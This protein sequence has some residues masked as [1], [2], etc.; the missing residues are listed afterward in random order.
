M[1]KFIAILLTI[2]LLKIG[3]L[4][5]EISPYLIGNNY[6]YPTSGS[7]QTLMQ[8]GNAID[9]ADFQTIRIGG[10]GANGYTNAQFIQY[11][12]EIQ[13]IG[14]EPIVQV[15]AS[16]TDAQV[17]D[18]IS[19]INIENELGVKFWAIGNEPD[20]D[21]GG[22]LSASQV[23][24]YIRQIAPILKSIDPS[25]KIIGPA[26]AGYSSSSFDQLLGGS[27]D[28]SGKDDNGNYYIDVFSFHTY[29]QIEITGIESNVDNLLVKL[30][31]VNADRPEAPISWMMGEFNMHWD[32]EEVTDPDG[33]VWSFHAGHVFADFYN[34]GMRKGASIL[35]PWSIFEGDGNRSGGDLGLFDVGEPPL[36]RSSYYH[37][38]MLGQNM[39]K[40]LTTDA[41]TQ[42]DVR[43]ISMKDSTGVS[44][45]IMNR[46]KEKSYT[47]SLKLNNEYGTNAPLQIKVDA[48]I[49][50][51]ITGVIP[52]FA[53]QMLAFDA[54]GN[55][56]KQYTYTSR[57]ADLQQGPKIEMM[58][59]A[60]N[61][62]PTIN[63]IEK[64]NIPADSGSYTVQ[65]SGIS[66]GNNCSQ[67]LT[68]EAYSLNPAIANASN[69][70][71]TSC[72]STGT[73]T[74]TPKKAGRTTI[75]VKLTDGGE[76]GCNNGSVKYMGI[77]VN[78]YAIHNIPALVECEDYFENKGLI[79]ENSTLGTLSFGYS[80]VGDYL[81]YKVNA[82]YTGTHYLTVGLASN[83]TTAA[84]INILEDNTKLAT[85][86]VE[87]TGGWQ[88]WATQMVSF[89]L[90]E[91]IHTLKLEF[92]KAGANLDFL[93][94]TTDPGTNN[95]PYTAITSPKQGEKLKSAASIVLTASGLDMDDA[96]EKVDFFV[97][98]NLVGTALNEPYQVEWISVFPGDH[99]L[100]TQIS[101]AVGATTE[102]KQ[103]SS[104][105]LETSEA[106]EIPGV[107]EA[108]SY[109]AMEGIQTEECTEGGLN[110]GYINAGDWLDY[111][112]SVPVPGKYT[113]KGR[114]SGWAN[115]SSFDLKDAAGTSL[116]TIEIPNSD[117]YQEWVDTEV[118][119]EFELSSGQQIIRI[120]ANTDKMNLNNF[121][122]EKVSATEL[123]SLTLSPSSAK[124]AIGNSIKIIATAVDANN[125][126]LYVNP[127]FSV[128]NNGLIN[129]YGVFLAHIDGTF[130]VTA[131][132]ADLE[133]S[134]SID[135]VATQENYTVSFIISD[136]ENS[137]LRNAEIKLQGYSQKTNADGKAMFTNIAPAEDMVFTI[138]KANYYDT[139]NLVTITNNDIE[140]EITMNK[141]ATSIDVSMENNIQLFPN[142]ATGNVVNIT[143]AKGFNL[144]VIDVSGNNVL[145][146]KLE[147]NNEVLNISILETGIY[148][149][150]IENNSST[151]THKFVV[152]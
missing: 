84:V 94:F 42:S 67:G 52:E 90:N 11:I 45:M 54:D 64:L 60:C 91:G 87:K 113:I 20:H 141:V 142:P 97:D 100:K 44:V 104:T 6:W 146:E 130:T 55:L 71:Y 137:V 16:K 145:L 10:F 80:D 85:L 122:F 111:L 83:A 50:K 98:N 129:E 149:I 89:D 88:T 86:T 61:A 152:K 133:A 1:K 57:D 118:S 78:S 76:P 134:V 32:N 144:S 119:N 150:R 21:G 8:V 3:A 25:I 14:A 102:S 43:L 38:M 131:K 143:N 9:T 5:Q 37:S 18:L 121:S 27:A 65:L 49:D 39:K 151:I 75:I 56:I 112:V 34:M 114:V 36:G 29:G 2:V 123:S 103:V 17:L 124:L 48:G 40:Y 51:Q 79:P 69:L 105:I 139:T 95:V 82:S 13:A 7:L 92:E 74:I 147:S 26:Y 70:D 120:Q 73:L 4:A 106:I 72:D 33:Y 81:L 117:G 127:E 108:E 116:A 128:D 63:F 22:N 31:K 96:I 148:F 12:K 15:S 140:L 136:E 68:I 58:E 110:V 99:I 135:V 35:C 41:S 30:N 101:D 107:V 138:S 132:I 53:T 46:D 59:T 23:G 93:I 109:I 62:A 28:V 47:Y 24:T 125:N 115:G 66:D 19:E 77:D 126:T